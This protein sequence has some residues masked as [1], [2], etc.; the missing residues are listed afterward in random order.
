MNPT[1]LQPYLDFAVETAWNAGRI[2]LGYFQRDLSVEFKADDSPITAADRE[3]EQ[4]IRRRIQHRWPGH[5]IMGEEYGGQVAPSRLTWIIDPI[6]GT[7]SFVCGVPLY[8]TL[9]ALVEGQNPLVGVI[10]LPALNETVYAARGLGCYW[11]GQVAR[12]SPVSD[13]KRAVL[14]ASNLN[15]FEMHGKDKAWKRLRRATYIQRTWGDAYGYALLATGRAEIMLDPV[16]SPWDCGPLPVIM[17]EAGGTFTDWQ[18]N[19][20]AFGGES[21]ATN[22]HLFDPVMALIRGDRE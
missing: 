13:I 9:L 15:K 8:S 7:R 5:A 14:L 10:H 6:D 16:M 1:S 18:G 19:R 2:T 20:I 17:E 12:V 21:V 4:E 22:G 3:A 11:N